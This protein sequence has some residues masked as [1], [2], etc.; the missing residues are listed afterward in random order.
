MSVLLYIFMLMLIA[1]I[2]FEPFFKYK[3]AC[4]KMHGK[5]I[6]VPALYFYRR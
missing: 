4:I 3:Y 6:E 2:T 1:Q 5:H